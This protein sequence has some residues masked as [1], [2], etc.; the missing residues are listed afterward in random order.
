M[1]KT[2]TVGTL[3]RFVVQAV[4]RSTSVIWSSESSVVVVS[5]DCIKVIYYITQINHRCTYWFAFNLLQYVVAMRVELLEIEVTLESLGAGQRIGSSPCFSRSY[6]Q[7]PVLPAQQTSL[8][9]L[10]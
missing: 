2:W 1:K 8:N 10:L 4:E 7:R 9:T 5:I 6:Q 3:E